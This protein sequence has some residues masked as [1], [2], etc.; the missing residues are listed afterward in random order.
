MANEYSEY[1][2]TPGYIIK[3]QQGIY[4]ISATQKATLGTRIEFNDGRVFYYA[5][6]G[7]SNLSAGKLVMSE[8]VAQV[9]KSVSAAVSVGE[10]SVTVATSSAITTA[11]EGFLQVNDSDGEG[12]QYK[13]KTCAANST[14]STYTDFTLYDPVSKALTTNSQVTVV[15]NPFKNLVVTGTTKIGKVVGVPPVDVTADYYF[16]CQTWGLANI[17]CDGTPA[18]DTLVTLGS[19]AGSFG[20]LDVA[21]GSAG[22]TNVPIGRT[23]GTVGVDTEYKPVWLSLIR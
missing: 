22:V 5:K 13:I 2:T 12:L 6:A 18:A 8:G 17:L 15:Y 19:V 10:Y 20:A 11:Q 1:Q 3:P 21:T 7:S 14:T 16:W 4:E 23:Y 9:N